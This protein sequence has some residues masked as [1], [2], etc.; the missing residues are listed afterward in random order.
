MTPDDEFH[1]KT[2]WECFKINISRKLPRRFV[3]DMLQKHG[4]AVSV[5]EVTGPG[6]VRLIVTFEDGSQ[7]K[8]GRRHGTTA[9]NKA[10]QLKGPGD[11][12]L[13]LETHSKVEK[14]VLGWGVESQDEVD[15]YIFTFDF[16]EGEFIY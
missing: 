2:F 12:Y 6:A 11:P 9:R 13:Y 16:T 3:K 14:G 4:G 10:R 5:E 8:L 7:F 1:L 15:G